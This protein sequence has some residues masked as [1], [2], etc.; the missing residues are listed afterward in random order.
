[1]SQDPSKLLVFGY[2]CKLFRDDERAA[3]I[4]AGQHLI[5][6]MGD[7]SLRID[8]YD[9]RGALHN[10]EMYEPQPGRG[11]RLDPTEGLSDVEKV[12]EQ[13]C[14]EER[15]RSLNNDDSE[16]VVKEEE[17][18]KRRK[19]GFSQVGFSYDTPQQE[20]L[21]PAEQNEFGP[22]SPPSPTEEDS[23]PYEPPSS[24]NLPPSM[25]TP[26]TVKLFSVIEK[27]ATFLANQGSQMEILL[28]AKQA[29]NPA[30]NFLNIDSP[31]NPFYKHLVK[32]IKMRQYVPQNHPDH[33]PSAPSLVPQYSDTSSLVQPNIA[34]KIPTIKYKKDE[35]CSYSKLI[36]KIKSVAPPPQFIAPAVPPP[37]SMSSAPPP[38]LPALYPPPP[39]EKA[40][41]DPEPPVKMSNAPIH[42]PPPDLQTIVDKMASY[43]SKNGR[44]FE[45][46]VKSKDNARFSF[47]NDGDKYHQYYLH[48]L[49][50]YKT[51]NYDPNLSNEPLAFKVKKAVV[52][53]ENNIALVN[54][55]P[56]EDSDSGEE[57][58]GSKNGANA[59]L[60]K[61]TPPPPAAASAGNPTSG[62][63]TL[64]GFLPPTS[65]HLKAEPEMYNTGPGAREEGAE[66][67]KT[68][69]E[70][71]KK[72]EEDRIRLENNMKV[73][74]RLA[75]AAREKMVQASREK[76]LQLERKRKAAQFLAQL[77]EKKTM[78]SSVDPV[79]LDEDISEADRE[80]VEEEVQ[81][82]IFG[83][84]E[85]ITAV[86]IWPP[87][88]PPQLVI[89]KLATPPPPPPRTVRSSRDTSPIDLSSDSE[90]GR[91][92]SSRSK[93]R[94]HKRHRSRS[95]DSRRKRR[96]RSRSR[97]SSRHKKRRKH[98]KSSRHKRSGGK[99]DKRDHHRKYSDRS[100]E[101]SGSDDNED[102]ES[103]PPPHK[104]SDSE[105]SVARTK[106]N[107]PEVSSTG[108][109]AAAGGGG[110]LSGRTVED[111]IQ[112]AV[113]KITEDL[114]A[115]VRAMLETKKL[116]TT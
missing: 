7:P 88:L 83:G 29:G 14:E 59:D 19:T 54:A 91:R 53:E 50:V 11:H 79:P 69:E 73:R 8:R 26:P 78:V 20:Q 105:G 51:G 75:A 84:E 47:L 22:S 45:E 76:A 48:K 30:F 80:E 25:V 18:A 93:S 86:N 34:P 82:E 63:P 43:V 55:L 72:E 4:D 77:A 41:P 92:S 68:E 52:K 101:G 57:G 104:K 60:P 115:K 109:E 98:K 89:P 110:R 33:S 17:E 37:P 13:L 15:W 10:I 112:P 85:K 5:P 96:H 1:M 102:V 67:G 40:S 46:V 16:D 103:S 58:E 108:E 87:P 97:S 61:E 90:D 44:N 94:R 100:D 38:P 65:F 64:K 21:Q 81:Q 39:P 70:I 2:A 114:R 111:V 95:R 113:S 49:Q 99:R 74:D 106:E 107:T 62:F 32:L 24:L 36:S 6:W 12:E 31:L 35:N 3:S 66:G 28:K 42:I 9:G 27:T 71:K 23:L 56:Y 116:T